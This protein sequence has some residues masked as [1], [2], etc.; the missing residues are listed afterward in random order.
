M[1]GEARHRLR[2]RSLRLTPIAA[3]LVLGVACPLLAQKTDVIT[4][5]NGDRLTGEI[6][7]YNQGRLALDTPHS[8][9]V[10]IKWNKILSIESTKLYDVET[11]DGV[12]HYGSL[13]PSDPVGQLTVV[14]GPETLTV[15]FFDV[16]NV[17]PVGKDFWLRWEGSVN[18]GFNYTQST[19]LVQFNLAADAT[20]RM[21]NYQIVS[22]LSA[23]F[24]QQQGV[25]AT[26][27]G[28]YELYYDRFLPNRWVAEVGI[29]FDRN[30]QLGLDLRASAGLA[31]GRYLVQTNTK[32]LILFA[33]LLGNHERSTTGEDKFTAEATV[34][35]RYTFF[36]YDFPK[37]TINASVQV[38]PSITESGRVRL[39]ATGS[40]QRE[41]I[42]DF[43]LTL[44]VFD[45]FDSQDPAT[46]VAKND[47]GPS[48]TLGWKF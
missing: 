37:L 18:L 4:F 1:P 31:W 10:S 26:E 43:Y 24:S 20:Y 14:S 8:G 2:N 44:S 15:G 23:F 17:A 9:W 46:G 45:S 34:G 11:I 30:L 6:K 41:I 13:A 48:L 33:G 28:T 12:H 21:R 27:R 39:E 29:G 3:S 22:N 40:V 36:M 35:T 32:Q 47:W 5:I 19:Q 16:F 38:Y 25:A 42:S 7:T